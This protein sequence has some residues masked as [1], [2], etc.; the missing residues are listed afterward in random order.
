MLFGGKC[1]LSQ[2]TVYT[3]YTPE[4]IIRTTIFHI[5]SELPR[6]STDYRLKHSKYCFCCH[7]DDTRLMKVTAERAAIV[8]HYKVK[9]NYLFHVVLRVVAAAVYGASKLRRF[10]NGTVAVQ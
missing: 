9:Y 4:V 10:F 1:C 7:G 2:L 8:L 5:N 6:L 3:Y